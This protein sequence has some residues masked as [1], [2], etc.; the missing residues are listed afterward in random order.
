MLN[1]FLLILN[2][3]LYLHSILD[4]ENDE[5]HSSYYFNNNKKHFSEKKCFCYLCIF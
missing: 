3:L 5:F 2:I 4:T 1:H